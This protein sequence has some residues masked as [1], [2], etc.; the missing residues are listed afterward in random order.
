MSDKEFTL[1]KRFI[2]NLVNQN[3]EAYFMNYYYKILK[4]IWYDTSKKRNKKIPKGF[5][6]SKFNM[7]QKVNHEEYGEGLICSVDVSPYG[8]SEKI[9]YVD[10]ID[11][12]YEF[13]E[14]D[15]LVK[16]K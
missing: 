13:C 7:G 4:E 16:W 9:Y 8:N 15:D 14:E 5:R 1:I 2:E 6:M 3:Y 12:G 11:S 10:F